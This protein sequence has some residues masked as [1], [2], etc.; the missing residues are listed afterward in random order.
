MRPILTLAL[1]VLAFTFS[2]CD[3]AK[4]SSFVGRWISK[5]TR[6]DKGIISSDKTDLIVRTITLDA[7][8]N[9]Q[10]SITLNGR[11]TQ[12]ASGK[13]SVLNDVFFLDYDNGQT[14]YLR[15]V[16]ITAERFVIRNPD[17]SERIYDRIQ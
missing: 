3:S 14:L 4:K 12:N 6:V 2:G 16:R 1:A 13:W 10:L 17:G 7:N 11:P 8:G 15:V 9:G 5:E